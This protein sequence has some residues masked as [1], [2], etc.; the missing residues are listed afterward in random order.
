DVTREDIALAHLEGF[1]SV[2]HL[3]RYT[4]LG[5]A[6]D[7]GR[8]SNVLGLALMAEARGIPI[9][10]QGTTMFRPPYAPMAIGALAGAHRE[11]AS[12]PTRL[13]PS[14][15]WAVEQNA[16]FVDAGLWKRAEWYRRAG[17]T[18]WRQSCDRE[19]RTVRE[20]VGFCDVS[21]LG[22]IDVLGP[23]AA[24]FLDRIYSNLISTLPVGKCRYG[25]MLRED[26]FAYDDGTVA[27]LSD[28]HYFMTT[29][30]A[31]AGLVMQRL[32]FAR[33]VLWPDLAVNVTSS[34]DQ[35]A[36][37]SVAG[38]KAR[39]L[40][41]R[42]V[43][44]A[45]DVSADGLA[46]MGQ[47][48]AQLPDGGPL[49][50]IYRISFSGEVAFEVGVPARFGRALC[51]RLKALGSDLGVAP[52]GTEALN[53]LRIEKGHVS[54][55]E[56][57]G[58]TTAGDLCLGG[59]MSKKKDFIGRTLSYRPALRAPDRPT[60]VGFKPCDTSETFHAGAHV[61][62]AAGGL[63]PAND[64]GYVTSVCYSPTL[65]HTIG[66]GLVRHGPDRHGEHVRIHDPLRGSTT[67]AELC[68]P[69]FYD[70]AGAV[71]RG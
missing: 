25:L 38:P 40:V 19:V 13:T 11:A 69:H 10:E 59:L 45:C 30:T 35:W 42:L 3:K 18:T 22:K 56:L 15:D 29:T 4:T 43:G 65:G 55:P 52:Y 31:N 50:R 44:N 17:E 71:Q 41:Q 8:L 53:V 23:D 49:A 7:Q 12:K 6:T 64:E 20:A 67:D 51:E 34:T 63:T 48:T 2:E 5:M 16:S 61:F 26:G 14:H 39:T 27:R 33:Q 9:A 47:T 58:M 68:A 28:Q 57:N 21:T 54:G 66:L 36:Q 24:I 37:I 70:P 60:L 46:F 1:R 62:A 32:D